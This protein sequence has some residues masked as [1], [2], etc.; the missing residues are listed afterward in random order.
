MHTNLNP[1]TM[2]FSKQTVEA[3]E[4]LANNPAVN[5]DRVVNPDNLNQDAFPA[6]DAFMQPCAILAAITPNMPNKAS[7][8]F[9]IGVKTTKRYAL[10]L[11]GNN[12]TF[13]E[14]DDAMLAKIKLDCAHTTGYPATG[15]GTHKTGRK[16]NKGYWLLPIGPKDIKEWLIKIS[17]TRT[18][19]L[20][21]TL[22]RTKGF[23]NRLRA[24][25]LA[26]LQNTQKSQVQ[27]DATTI[28]PK[29]IPNKVWDQFRDDVE[30]KR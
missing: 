30:D 2:R 17:T 13:L 24:A 21:K 6:S 10:M 1:F 14:I 25:A 5:L 27:I 22:K 3:L 28:D 9:T 15:Y 12:S 26:Q 16:L 11:L 23:D 7:I 29:N 20:L 18:V 19:K 4:W 8:L